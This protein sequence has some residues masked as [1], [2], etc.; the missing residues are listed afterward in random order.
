MG[1]INLG[2]IADAVDTS[3]LV[4]A[5]VEGVIGADDEAEGAAVPAGEPFVGGGVFIAV[6]GEDDALDATGEF[7]EP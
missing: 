6:G 3:V 4:V 1:G 5:D 2:A 7:G